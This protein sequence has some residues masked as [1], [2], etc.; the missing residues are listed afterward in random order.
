VSGDHHIGDPYPT[1]VKP[2]PVESLKNT[3]GEGLL[4]RFL[5]HR[6]K[7]LHPKASLFRGEDPRRHLLKDAEQTLSRFFKRGMLKGV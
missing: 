4:T 1:V 7:G 5:S 3:L 6:H 2:R